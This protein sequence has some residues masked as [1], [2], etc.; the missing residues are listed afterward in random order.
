MAAFAFPG[1]GETGPA[2]F[3][4][5]K[6]EEARGESSFLEG[7]AAGIERERVLGHGRGVDGGVDEV[8][9]DTGS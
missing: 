4:C 2:E 9:E 6:T 5:A 3:V 7:P 8:G 1:H